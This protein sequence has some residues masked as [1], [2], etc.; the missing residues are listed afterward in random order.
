MVQP[1]AKTIKRLFAEC[2]NGCA[3]PKCNTPMVDT[4]SG[5]IVGEICH[6]KGKSPGGPRYDAAQTERKRHGYDNLLLLCD[7]HHK[8]V[9]DDP[10]AYTVERLLNMKR[11]YLE[12]VAYAGGP[13]IDDQSAR[14]LIENM[15]DMV[16]EGGLSQ[17]D[18]PN[19]QQLQAL[20]VHGHVIQAGGDVNI[21]VPVAPTT[22]L[23]WLRRSGCPQ[24]DMRRGI[25][26]VQ[27][28]IGGDMRISGADPLPISIEV[29]WEGVGI[30]MDW[31]CPTPT[32]A[33]RNEQ[34]AFHMGWVTLP[35][36]PD[37]T[38]IM[39]SVRFWWNDEQHG[40]TWLWYLVPHASKQGVWEWN[41][42]K[43][44]GTRQPNIGDTW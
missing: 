36:K 42:Q 10:I 13:T 16:I 37:Q 41:H 29:K 25:Q 27:G 14:K 35:S 43:G 22:P 2:G 44:S 34:L 23:P 26:P 3:F 31:T 17:E 1:S 15:N 33:Y 40:A 28:E 38:E 11:E 7:P 12:C 8:I 39:F 21:G 5:T 18:S 30:D 9:D 6:I 32:V 19:A 24:F 4:E 20:D